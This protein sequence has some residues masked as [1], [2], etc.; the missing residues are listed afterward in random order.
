MSIRMPQ[1]L[2]LADEPS[3]LP[4]RVEV[5]APSSSE[6]IGRVAVRRAAL[7]LTPRE[8]LE[9]S[10]RAYVDSLAARPTFTRI[11]TIEALAAG[12][13]VRELRDERFEGFIDFYREL[14]RRARE[15]DPSLDEPTDDL[16]V[17]AIGAIAEL[18]RRTVSMHG[19]ERVPELYDTIH[20]VVWAL[21]LGGTKRR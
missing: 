21:V 1:P 13:K 11:F 12:G 8:G 10:L 18:V 15:E 20:D 9:F 5:V 4:Q 2:D 17:A 14:A 16:I 6:Y 19:P 7:A 3:E